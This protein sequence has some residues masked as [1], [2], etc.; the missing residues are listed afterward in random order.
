VLH[1]ALED[2]PGHKIW[3]RDFTGAAGLF[4]VELKLASGE[5][6][7]KMFDGFELFG[8][9][10]SWGGY[11]SLIVPS[12]PRRTASS[13]RAQGT[14]LRVSTGLEHPED[15]ISDLAAGLNRLASV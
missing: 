2:D 4:G 12:N 3:K 8:M 13:F 15:L 1:P 11:E 10:Y 9:G 5:A 14:L 6:L 7:A